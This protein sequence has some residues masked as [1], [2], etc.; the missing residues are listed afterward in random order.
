MSI[1]DSIREIAGA[2][3]TMRMF[4]AEVLSVDNSA[5]TCLVVLLSGGVSNEITARLMANVDDGAFLIPAVGSQVIVTMSDYVKPFVSMFSEL[6]SI[7]WLGGEY[8]GVP[9]VTH[10]TSGTSGLLTRLNRIEDKV[11]AFISSYNSHAHAVAV[12]GTSGT[13]SPT[14][15]QVTGALT[16]TQQADIQHP[17]ITH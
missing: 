17:N 2:R 7:V 14:P 12:T 15:Q 16:P 1:V 3:D 4:D 6:E 9:I 8:E 5:R 13:A 10:P 11:N